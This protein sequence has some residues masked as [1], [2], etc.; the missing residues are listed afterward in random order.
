[1]KAR[2]NVKRKTRRYYTRHLYVDL[3]RK[4]EIFA[5]ME[6]VSIE[7]GFNKLLEIAFEALER[8]KG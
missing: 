2:Y 7:E 6:R 1:M 8:G 3:H 5:T 4:V